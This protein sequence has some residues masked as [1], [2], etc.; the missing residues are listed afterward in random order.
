MTHSTQVVDFGWA[1]VGDD[2]DEV[3]CIAK[4][5]VVEE[6]FDSGLVPVFVDVIDTA[7]VECGCT[8]N[9]TM[10]LW[11]RNAEI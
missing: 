1:D 5:T 4:I 10:D 3:S 7:G 6:E 11:I 2:G 8:A 9:D